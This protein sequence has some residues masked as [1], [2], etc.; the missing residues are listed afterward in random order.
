VA[1]TG[2]PAGG[3]DS[4]YANTVDALAFKNS[5]GTK[6]AII[7]NSGSSAKQT[8]IGVGSTTYQV[9]IPANGFAT[10]NAP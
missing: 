9:T 1:L 7:Y 6:V 5:D 10:L 2:A 4:Q 3:S 8:T